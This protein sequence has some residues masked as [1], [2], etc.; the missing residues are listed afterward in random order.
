MSQHPLDSKKEPLVDDMDFSEPPTA[1]NGEANFDGK[2]NFITNA[3]FD[4]AL[5]PSLTSDKFQSN[6]KDSTDSRP[7]SASSEVVDFVTE[8]RGER[9]GSS[10]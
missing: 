4:V 9:S 3:I 1:V 2:F 6:T 10:G 5:A 8:S 7:V